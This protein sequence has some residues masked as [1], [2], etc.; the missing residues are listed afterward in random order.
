MHQVT[1]FSNQLLLHGR[2]HVY[3]SAFLVQS[4]QTQVHLITT[5]YRQEKFAFLSTVLINRYLRSNVHSI[6]IAYY[7]LVAHAK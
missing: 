7:K 6:S 5:S 1:S 4:L 3:Y 2:P